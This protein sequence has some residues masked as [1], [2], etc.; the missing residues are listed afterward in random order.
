MGNIQEMPG[1]EFQRTPAFVCLMQ[2]RC[3]VYSKE[4]THGMLHSTAG[5]QRVN[6][7]STDCISKYG[8]DTIHSGH[9]R[10]RFHLKREPTTRTVLLPAQHGC[11]PGFG[12]TGSHMNTCTSQ[13]VPSTYAMQ[14]MRGFA[15]LTGTEY[16][17]S[18][19]VGR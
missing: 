7:L 9:L 14:G 10:N 1:R 8:H 18:L 16:P 17:P 15:V 5:G 11:W 19:A 3:H 13:R 12:H 2:D 4:S 6:C